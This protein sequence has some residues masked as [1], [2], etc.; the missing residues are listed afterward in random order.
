MYRAIPIHKPIVF[1]AMKIN[2]EAA[3]RLRVLREKAGYESAQRFADVHGIPDVTYRSHENGTRN[4]TIRAAKMYAPLL[5]STYQWILDGEGDEKK[6]ANEYNTADIAIIYTL[7]LL[8]KSLISTGALKA[9]EVDSSLRDAAELYRAHH[10]PVAVEVMESLRK[11][12]GAD[13]LPSKKETLRL[14]FELEPRGSA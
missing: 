10:L 6:A 9:Q 2:K 5:D 12:A 11:S 1:S 14:L 7:R 4:I 3:E 8:L 13:I